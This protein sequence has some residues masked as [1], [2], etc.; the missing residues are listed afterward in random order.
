MGFTEADAIEEVQVALWASCQAFPLTDL[1]DWRAT[2]LGED[3]WSVTSTWIDPL[4]E[5]WCLEWRLCEL[6]RDKEPAN[7]ATAIFEDIVR[8]WCRSLRPW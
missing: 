3:L 8:N 1:H 5:R 7:R 6:R 4:G 2:Y